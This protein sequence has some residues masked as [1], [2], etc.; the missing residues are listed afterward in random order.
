MIDVF[1]NRGSPLP[2]SDTIVFSALTFGL[3]SALIWLPIY[4]HSKKDF[5]DIA[6]I[7]EQ[8]AKDL[9]RQK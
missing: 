1:L 7:L 2:I 8:R 5:E 6:S 9:E 4:K 3:I